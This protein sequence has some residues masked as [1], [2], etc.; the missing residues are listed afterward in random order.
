MKRILVTGEAGF[1][2]RISRDDPTDR[3]GRDPR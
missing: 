1:I 2:G 3:A